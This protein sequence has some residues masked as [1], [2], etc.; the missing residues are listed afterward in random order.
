MYKVLA[1]RFVCNFKLLLIKIDRNSLTDMKTSSLTKN[2]YTINANLLS[3]K[4]LGS[5]A[6]RIL[7]VFKK[8]LVF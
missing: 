6:A 5:S 8:C 4:W 3:F 2:S 1:F 7:A